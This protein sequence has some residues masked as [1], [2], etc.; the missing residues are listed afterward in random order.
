M[1]N[2][3]R[4]SEIVEVMSSNLFRTILTAFGV[5][6]GIL[7]LILLLALSK[8]LEKGVK[9]DFDGIATNTMFMWAQSTTQPFK[10]L[11]K[12][13]VYNFKIDDVEAIRQNVPGLKYISPRNRLG[14]QGGTSNVIKGT[15][16]D[17]FDV[18]GDYPEIIQ[19]ETMDVLDGRF[20]NQSD[21]NEKRKVAVIGEGVRNSLYEKG[22][23]VLG[24]YIKIRGVNFMV[25]GVYGIK[26]GRGDIER[27]QKRIYVPF[28]T[29]S[30]AFN[31]ADRVGW[32][33]ITAHD[34]ASITNLKSQVFNV[35]KDRHKISPSDVRA[36][37]HFDLYE[38]FSKV[39]RL[40]V[41]IRFI[42]FVVGTMVLL[43]GTIGVSNIM[44]IVIKERT[45]EIG[46]RRALGESPWSIRGQILL[47]SVFLTII[48]GMAGIIFA[49]LLLYIVNYLLEVNG[50]VDMFTNPSINLGV[51]AVALG[52]LVG[53]GL[54]A[55]F[56]P[57][58]NAIKVKPIDALRSE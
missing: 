31:M 35:I 34:D 23:P 45:K 21:L 57:A 15:K 30:Q 1:F 18:Y 10:G 53:S 19:Q 36:V 16:S 55:G 46:I 47:E 22:E 40:F 50:P 42:A 44:L 32:M 25:I 3:D 56:L 38:E 12:G 52:I 7:I 13:R 17:S 27:K 5:F 28:A 41:A 14:R 29:F 48:S 11:P 39:E 24:S 8:G 43:S 6:W 54:L 2:K 51:V 9:M 4:W 26:G 33:A 49:T 58:Q 37:G 20:L